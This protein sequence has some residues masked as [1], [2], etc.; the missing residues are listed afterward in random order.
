MGCIV[1]KYIHIYVWEERL[2]GLCLT[3][4]VRDGPLGRARNLK[5]IKKRDFFAEGGGIA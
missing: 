4:E 2:N 1:S 5:K 3:C